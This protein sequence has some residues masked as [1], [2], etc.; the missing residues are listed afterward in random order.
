VL[1]NDSTK[2]LV[3][4]ED[5]AQ[6]IKIA[7]DEHKQQEYR[8]DEV[9]LDEKPNI[10]SGAHSYSSDA[11]PRRQII[12]LFLIGIAITL[13]TNL[14]SAFTHTSINTAYTKVN[15][16]LNVSYEGRGQ[17]LEKQDYVWLRS[18]IGSSWYAGQV[19]GAQ[20]SPFVTD[21]WGRK[22]KSTSL[23]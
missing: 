23:S 2:Q 4:P 16:Y 22:R 21:R 9:Q 10:E 1:S 15:E 5:A 19:I 11:W 3:A 8:L 17:H 18:I 12:K 20:F 14:P 13:T 6:L 7:L